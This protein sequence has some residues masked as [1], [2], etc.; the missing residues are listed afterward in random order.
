MRHLL[1]LWERRLAP[2]LATGKPLLQKIQNYLE[3]E[4][5]Y[6]ALQGG[7][8]KN[9]RGSLFR[10]HPLNSAD[11][12]NYFI[13]LPGFSMLEEFRERGAEISSLKRR[14][15]FLFDKEGVSNDQS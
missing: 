3:I 5:E 8:Q 12:H 15:P 2:M 10:L 14:V 9:S 7:N 6:R 13:H 4:A 11:R 1:G